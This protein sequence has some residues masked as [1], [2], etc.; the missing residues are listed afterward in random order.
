M[1]RPPRS[2]SSGSPPRMRGKGQDREP[3]DALLRITPAY[4]GKSFP[5]HLVADPW[6]DHPRVCGEK[7]GPALS[8][9][10][11]PGSPPRMRGKVGILNPAHSVF[12]DHPR[13]CGEKSSARV[14]LW[15]GIGS[16]PRMRG[17]VS[18]CCVCGWAARITPAYAGKSAPP[19]LQISGKKDH[20]RVCGEKFTVPM[21][22]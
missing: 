14:F 2:R 9:R 6:R 15:K 17:K 16:P 18:S 7:P 20:P 19:F 21:F 13:V 4:A 22:G 3:H 8:Q 1:Q 5:H 12:R 11:P 10:P